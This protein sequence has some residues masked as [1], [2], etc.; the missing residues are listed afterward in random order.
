QGH[1]AADGLRDFAPRRQPLL[2]RRKARFG[3]TGAA[4]DLVEARAI[5]LAVQPLEGRIVGDLAR[6]LG[7]GDIQAHLPRA[8]VERGFGDELPRELLV[9]LERARLIRRDR[10]AELAAQ[11][12]QAIVV[13]LAELVDG[14]LGR[15]DLGDG[16]AA[17]PAEN[18]ADAPDGETDGDQAEHDGHD[19]PPQPIGGSLANTAKHRSPLVW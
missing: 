7:V 4:D 19:S 3:E 15:A 1:L 11:L 14:D 6:D 17:E 13:D 16:R 9:K 8:L 2:L 18:V 10:A 12:L 5:E